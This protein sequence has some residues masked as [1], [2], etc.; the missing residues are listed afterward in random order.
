MLLQLL[1][2]LFMFLL[3]LLLECSSSIGCLR[4]RSAGRDGEGTTKSCSSCGSGGRGGR[5]GSGLE[6][7]FWR[8][9]FGRCR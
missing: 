2:L 1:L 4:V 3:L 6:R 8:F 9:G 7:L 5:G